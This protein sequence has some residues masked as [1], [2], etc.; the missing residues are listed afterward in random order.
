MTE[1][2]EFIDEFVSEMQRVM[3]EHDLEKGSTWKQQDLEQLNSNLFEEIREYEIKNDPDRELI[4]IA[5][6]CYIIW[7]KRKFLI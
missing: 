5:N 3:E 6:S 4:D 2:A 7:A 1:S